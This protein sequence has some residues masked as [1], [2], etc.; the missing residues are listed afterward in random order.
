MAVDSFKNPSAKAP[1][2][3]IEFRN[4][5]EAMTHRKYVSFIAQRDQAVIVEYS[6]LQDELSDEELAIVAETMEATG[7]R[8]QAKIL[9]EERAAQ[10]EQAELEVLTYENASEGFVPNAVF[11]VARPFSTPLINSYGFDRARGTA[12]SHWHEGIDIFGPLGTDLLAAEAGTITKIGNGRLGGRTVW[13]TGV[14]GSKWYYA[15]LHGFAPGLTIGQKVEAGDV[16][17]YLGD[18]GNARGTPPHLHLEIHP[19]DKRVINPYPQLYVLAAR[20]QELAEQQQIDGAGD[21][22]ESSLNVSSGS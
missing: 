8:N 13:L 17:G 11:P 6:K 22:G 15:H 10:V 16:I 5:H 3:D 12:D 19:P 9:V 20:E 18:S 2:L 21:N 7:E 1:K 4:S 14:S